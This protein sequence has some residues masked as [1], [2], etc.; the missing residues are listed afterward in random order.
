M[1]R[2]SSISPLMLLVPPL[3]ARSQPLADR[4][5]VEMG[6]LCVTRVRQ[7][8]AHDLHQ[9]RG[10]KLDPAL[11]APP[12]GENHPQLAMLGSAK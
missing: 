7:R 5:T 10:R 2:W 1:R 8:L 11:A 3:L 12:L 9:R 6:N 4:F